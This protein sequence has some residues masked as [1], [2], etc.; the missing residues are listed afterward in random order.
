MTIKSWNGDSII[1]VV[2]DYT[3]LTGKSYIQFLPSGYPE[4]IIPM[5]EMVM[6]YYSVYKVEL[7]GVPENWKWHCFDENGKYACFKYP[8]ETPN[9]EEFETLVTMSK[10]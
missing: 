4:T 1:F 10:L 7:A 2:D 8:H 6:K 9:V 3:S 5:T